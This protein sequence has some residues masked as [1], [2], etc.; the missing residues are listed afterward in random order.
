MLKI[1]YSSPIDCTHKH[2]IRI[3]F[4]EFFESRRFCKID[5]VEYEEARLTGSYLVEDI[6]DYGD[7][8]VQLGIVSVD[9][10]QE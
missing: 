4:F 10:V 3:G 1:F 6:V 8:H 5:F 7:L 2:C 9:G